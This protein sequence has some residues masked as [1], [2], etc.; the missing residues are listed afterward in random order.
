[1]YVQKKF[2]GDLKGK[3]SFHVGKKWFLSFKIRMFLKVL[4]VLLILILV[5]TYFI[6]LH[7]LHV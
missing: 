5:F 1:M 2:F 7:I 4:L 3:F 6:L